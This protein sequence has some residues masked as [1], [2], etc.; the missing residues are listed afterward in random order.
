MKKTMSKRNIAKFHNL[1]KAEVP[2][3]SIVKILKID[4]NTLKKFSPSA[5]KAFKDKQREIEALAVKQK[6]KTA[7]AAEIVAAAAKKVVEDGK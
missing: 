4:K 2:I 6:A 3:S 7:E 1:L 5:V